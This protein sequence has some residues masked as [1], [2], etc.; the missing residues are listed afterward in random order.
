[1]LKIKHAGL[2]L[3]F[4]LFAT[5]VFG[6]EICADDPITALPK[7]AT[8]A[9]NYGWTIEAGQDSTL[10][11]NMGPKMTCRAFIFPQLIDPHHPREIPKRS[12]KVEDAQRFLD[13][14]PKPP[15]E[16]ITIN[17]D[18]DKSI[19]RIECRRVPDETSGLPVTIEKFYKLTETPLAFD[20]KPVSVAD[21]HKA[22]PGTSKSQ[23]SV[24]DGAV[25]KDIRREPRGMFRAPDDKLLQTSDPY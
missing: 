8:F 3:S 14:N 17:I 15:E 4:A 21:C 1:M 18:G 19:S 16:V 12:F 23:M 6:A 24:D 5:R 22:I 2:F 9:N 11:Y 7:G 20:F 13:V 25:V 10:I